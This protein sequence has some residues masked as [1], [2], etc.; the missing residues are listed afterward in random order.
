[1]R[2]SGARRRGG[3]HTVTVRLGRSG[4]EAVAAPA[5]LDRLDRTGWAGL[6]AD[7]Q[8]GRVCLGLLALLFFK[9]NIDFSFN[10]NYC[11]AIANCVNT[12]FEFS[13]T[14]I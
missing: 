4:L 1:M 14:N 8:L 7:I 3:G 5:L 13:V 10:G 12:G 6:R 2:G 9:T 11:H